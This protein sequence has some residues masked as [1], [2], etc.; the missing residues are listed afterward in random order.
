MARDRSLG[1]EHIT[2]K[3]TSTMFLLILEYKFS[4]IKKEYKSYLLRNY[5]ENPE[6]DDLTKLAYRKALR[7]SPYM[8]IIEKKRDF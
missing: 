8:T 4:N 2:K 1:Y 7:L 3:Y 5:L 6:C